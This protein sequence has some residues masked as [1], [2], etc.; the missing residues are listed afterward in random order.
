[1]AEDCEEFR[2]LKVANDRLQEEILSCHALNLQLKE[3]IFSIKKEHKLQIE[4]LERKVDA[5]ADASQLQIERLK[6]SL[7]QAKA[8]RNTR[9]DSETL[10][11][12]IHQ[13]KTRYRTMTVTLATQTEAVTVGH[14]GEKEEAVSTQT[15]AATVTPLGDK[16]EDAQ[17]INYIDEEYEELDRNGHHYHNQR[18]RFNLAMQRT[19]DATRKKCALE[20]ATRH[21]RLMKSTA[22]RIHDMEVAH[23]NALQLIREEER[24]KGKEFLRQRNNV[25]ESRIITLEQNIKIKE[26]QYDKSVS[27]AQHAAVAAVKKVHAQELKQIMKQHDDVVHRLNSRCEMERSLSMPRD[28][29]VLGQLSTTTKEL[30]RCKEIIRNLLSNRVTSIE[31]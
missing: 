3:T 31:E 11:Q 7:F 28:E 14:L 10:P 19:I 30:V 24:A 16:E 25:L 17:K 26:T 21:R 9:S 1:M 4:A 18:K 23:K 22:G 20:E 13:S 2:G 8:S 12:I 15:K 29:Q 5:A 27:D 6:E